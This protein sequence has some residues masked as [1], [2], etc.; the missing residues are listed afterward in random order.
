MNTTLKNSLLWISIIPISII[1]SI[2]IPEIYKRFILFF[3]SEEDTIVSTILIK[4][5]LFFLQGA[6]AIMPAFFLAPKH[7]IKA[8]GILCVVFVL[9]SI[10]GEYYLRQH[11]SGIGY[12]QVFARILGSVMAYFV[13]KNNFEEQKAK[14]PFKLSQEER[15]NLINEIKDKAKNNPAY[16]VHVEKSLLQFKENQDKK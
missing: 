9:I 16:K 7:K 2:F 15:E 6:L 10:Y 4:W 3:I 5:T 13:M 14:L 11:N 12:L 8:A 1:C